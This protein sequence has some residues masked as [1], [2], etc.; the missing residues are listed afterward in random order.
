MTQTLFTGGYYRYIGLKMLW[1]RCLRLEGDG[2]L[3][4]SESRVLDE[5]AWLS[6]I[7]IWDSCKHSILGGGSCRFRFL[8]GQPPPSRDFALQVSLTIFR[9]TLGI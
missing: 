6:L 7:V 8:V 2:V 3:T 5:F 4:P 1:E 9:V